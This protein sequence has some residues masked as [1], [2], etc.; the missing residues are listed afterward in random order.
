MKAERLVR[1]ILHS[2]RRVQD[3]DLDQGG[4]GRGGESG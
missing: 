2:N 4:G 3:G 1:M